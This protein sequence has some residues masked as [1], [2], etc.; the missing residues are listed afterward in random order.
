MAGP[1]GIVVFLALLAVAGVILFTSPGKAMG[2]ENRQ[3]VL[4]YSVYL[5]LF[6]TPQTS[7][8]RLLLPLFPLALVIARPSSWTLRWVVVVASAL[9]QIWWVTALWSL[10][11]SFSSPP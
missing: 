2:H 8:F 11:G 7:T 10:G 3:F 1:L 9:L 4:G 5:L 6:F